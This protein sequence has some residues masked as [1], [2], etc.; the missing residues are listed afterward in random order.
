MKVLVTGGAGFIGS[1]VSDRLISLGH[2]VTIIDNFATGRLENIP[3]EAD[4]RRVDLRDERLTEVFAEVQP[5]VVFHLAAHIDV[6]RSVR[7]PVYDASIN[8]LGSLN[9]FEC[10]RAH[11]TRKVIYSGTAGALFGEPSYIPV[12]EGHP[13]EPI[14]P[15]G[16][17][18]HTVEHYLFAYRANHGLEYT[19]L[20]YPNVYGPRQDPHGEAG[21]VAIF[22]L[23]MLSGGQ[24]VIFGDGTKTRDYCYVGDIVDANMIALNSPVNGVYNLGRGI[25]VSDLEI[26]EAVREAVGSDIRPVFAPV[27]PGEVEHIA[28]DASKAEREL[29]WKWKVGLTEG[30]AEAVAHYRAVTERMDP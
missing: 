21:V 10:C 15:Y 26:F 13:V 24:P 22:S 8:I 3:A 12:D 16:I 17:S 6:T 11:G 5:E 1:H 19:V 28:L 27:R 7:E 2:S 20:R 4:L 25:E 18:K 23:L 29:G 14:S 9:L 30:V